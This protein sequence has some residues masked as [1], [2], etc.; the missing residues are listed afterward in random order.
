MRTALDSNVLSAL[1]SEEPAARGIDTALSEARSRGGL[2]ICA[3]VYCEL[4][5]YP[6]A[7]RRFVQ[8]FLRETSILV[9]FA[10]D[11]EIWQRAATSFAAYADRR[12]K[13]GGR[14]PKRLLADFVIG[15]HALV[16][17]D[18]LMTLE[19]RRYQNDFPSLQIV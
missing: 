5:A 3:P 8:D 17:A 14:R 18:R 7:T 19:A 9:D 4:L 2:V 13:S 11:E 16:A 1:W 12:R 15:A 10:L 6:H